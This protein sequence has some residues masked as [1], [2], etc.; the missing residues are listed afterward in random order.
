MT[1]I[2]GANIDQLL[3]CPWPTIGSC[4]IDKP[5]HVQRGKIEIS[6]GCRGAQTIPLLK[7]Q[8]L[9]LHDHNPIEWGIDCSRGTPCRFQHDVNLLF[10]DWSPWLKITNGSAVTDYFFEFHWTSS[11]DC[12]HILTGRFF[13]ALQWH[14][15]T[16][17]DLYEDILQD[18][19]ST[20]LNS[21]HRTISYAV[22]CLKKKK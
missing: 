9:T 14:I 6:S 11:I 16:K 20:R 3:E 17:P 22:F 1:G 8:L 18:R 21:S 7:S 10:F 19:K 2:E 4:R 13:G 12:Q 15:L 5:E